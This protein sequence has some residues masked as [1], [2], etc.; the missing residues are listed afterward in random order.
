MQQ[1][2]LKNVKAPRVPKDQVPP[3]SQHQMQSLLDV[4]RRTQAPE[5]NVALILLLVDTGLRCA[6]L[7]SLTVGDV[8][9]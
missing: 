3:L 5:R 9:D 7:C 8:E 1:T 4:A 6:E 2:P